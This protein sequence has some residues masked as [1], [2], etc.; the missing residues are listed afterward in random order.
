MSANRSV[1]RSTRYIGAGRPR[2]NAGQQTANADI[3]MRSGFSL[4]DTESFS[5]SNFANSART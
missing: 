4:V 2:K 1:D 5:F 3:H